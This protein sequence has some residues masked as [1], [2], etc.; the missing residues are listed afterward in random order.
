MS[1]PTLFLLKLQDSDLQWKIA[2]S[3]DLH[4]DKFL[5]Q[6]NEKSF[7]QMPTQTEINPEGPQNITNGAIMLN[8]VVV[9]DG[10]AQY[11][12]DSI[13]EWLSEINYQPVID[14]HIGEDS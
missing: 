3:Y 13:E 5:L 7:H 12:A 10:W 11:T 9:H 1:D 6:I 2:L 14:I 8:E 4:G